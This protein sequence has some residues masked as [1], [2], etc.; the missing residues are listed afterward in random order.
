ML[1]RSIAITYFLQKVGSQNSSKKTLLIFDLGGGK[2]DV[3]ILII[4]ESTIRVLAVVGDTKLGGE[5]FDN[6][7]VCHFIEKFIKEKERD[8]SNKPR[9]LR[10]LRAACEKA[11]RV[12]S[13]NTRTVVEIDALD[14]GIDFR[15]VI[16]REDFEQLNMR[17][18]TRS[19]GYVERCLEDANINRSCID[20]VILV[21]GSTRIPRMQQLLQVRFHHGFFFT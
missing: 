9:S 3:S 14:D 17:L 10:R 18:F 11:K 16:T 8:I 5:D 20:D 6:N 15:S 19:I 21:G 12:L 13:T 4:N 7:M 2:L 1:F